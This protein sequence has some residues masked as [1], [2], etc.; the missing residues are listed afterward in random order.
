MAVF[1]VGGPRSARPARPATRSPPAA[2]ADPPVTDSCA[3]GARC[4]ACT[5]TR[6]A[7]IGRA[8][9]AWPGFL[10]VHRVLRPVRDL[11]RHWPRR[12]QGWLAGAG[13]PLTDAR[14]KRHGNSGPG[15][16]LGQTSP[17]APG[18][19]H[20]RDGRHD[21]MAAWQAQARAAAS[22]RRMVPPRRPRRTRRRSPRPRGLHLPARHRQLTS[23]R[24]ALAANRLPHP[25]WPSNDT[26]AGPGP[27][28]CWTCDLIRVLVSR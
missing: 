20:R 4:P 24:G 5:R 14:E 9:A 16:H 7:R 12:R 19:A 13:E 26:P 11:P 22:P 27:Q 17:A 3:A 8:W 25:C 23:F 21:L 18:T 6:Q 1:L 28:A 15:V 2:G 10:A